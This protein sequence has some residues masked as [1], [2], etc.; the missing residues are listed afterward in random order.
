MQKFLTLLVL[1]LMLLPLRLQAQNADASFSI[2]GSNY[3]ATA[4]GRGSSEAAAV[5]AARMSAIHTLM[6][7]LDKDRLFEELLYR[8]PPIYMT[9]QTLESRQ[10]G[11]DWLARVRF[12]V[13]AESI[14]ILYNTNY[15]AAVISLLDQAENHHTEADSGLALARAAETQSDLAQALT[16]YWQ[17][18]DS[19]A[20]GL[21]LLEPIEDASIFSSSGKR[22]AADLREML[23]TTVTSAQT[24]IGRIRAAEQKLSKSEALASTL[25]L[26]EE[27]ENRNGQ[28]DQWISSTTPQ[29]NRVEGQN[30]GSLAAL[31]SALDMQ[32]NGL[33]DDRTALG[34]IRTAIGKEYSLEQS[35]I[36]IAGNTIDRQ[37]KF[38]REAR[39]LVDREIRDPAIARAKRRQ[40]ARALLLKNPE[41]FLGLRFYL[42][43]GLDPR[44]DGFV[45]SNTGLYE[46][47]ISSEFKL[48]QNSG[49][50]LQSQLKKDDTI[51]ASQAT[52]QEKDTAWTQQFSLGFFGRSLLGLGIGWDWY[53]ASNG[54]ELAKRLAPR[55]VFGGFTSQ[56][57][58]PAW[59]LAFSWEL[60]H[61]DTGDFLLLNYL[62][63]AAEAQLRFASRA[64]LQALL[65]LRLREDSRGDFHN[66]LHYSLGAGFRLPPPFLWGL[67]FQGLVSKP[68]GRPEAAW[69]SP[70][71]FRLFVEYSF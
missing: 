20:A 26:L 64:E 48:G 17:A 60:P 15:L 21:R 67:E 62:N 31:R 10:D 65:A 27:I 56:Y 66:Q 2:D 70:M 52:G 71:A 38:L 69:S 23:T 51:L 29:L 24:G 46:F 5:N 30:A 32:L 61:T 16:L 63:L 3:E 53:R 34:R 22:K 1:G 45:L 19:A 8:N 37:A 50:W 54:T 18:N 68:A 41:R 28:R 4:L 42:P 43:F 36:S 44:A 59:L 13:D 11:R 55:L 47:D 9:F 35:R 39:R 7:A 33:Q 12:Q 6:R 58:L 40:A 57:S 25:Q 14:R 49:I